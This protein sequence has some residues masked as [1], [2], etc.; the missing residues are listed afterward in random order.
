M[1][2]LRVPRTLQG[3]PKL[4][5]VEEGGKSPRDAVAALLSEG[6]TGHSLHLFSWRIQLRGVSDI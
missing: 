6:C 1:S 5:S 2:S 3:L 4:S